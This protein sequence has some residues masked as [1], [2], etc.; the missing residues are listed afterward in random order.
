M[1]TRCM[2]SGEYNSLLEFDAL[3]GGAPSINWARTGVRSFYDNYSG[4][5]YRANFNPALT[6][7]YVGFAWIITT[8][9]ASEGAFLQWK[10]GAT[11]LGTLYYDKTIGGLRLY[12][13][14]NATLLAASAP[15]ITLSTAFYLEVHVKIHDSLGVV[16]LR[17]NG[18][19]V[20]S[21]TGD[22]QPGAE[23]SVDV[24]EWSLIDYTRTYVDDVVVNDTTGTK[25]NSWPDGMKVGVL[26]PSEA[27]STTQWTPSA[28]AN[29][30]CVDE[31]NP[32]VTDY[33]QAT[34]YDKVDLYAL[35]DLPAEAKKIHAVQV[36][37]F[38]LRA[39]STVPTIKVG[40]K[41]DGTEYYSD[42]KALGLTLAKQYNV[43]DL[44]PKTGLEW[45]L[46]DINALEVGI[47]SAA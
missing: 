3:S 36:D 29:Y 2:I 46:A 12:R 22:T 1:A 41:T 28:G 27:G 38:A 25:N 44:N 7:F 30:E 23:T 11:V 6:E 26:R 14:A 24:V 20:L 21:F 39:G 31:L 8:V 34:A 42:G 35:P 43:W 16:E 33:V 19:P 37:A 32:S 9:N 10:S 5:Y 18:L 15:I 4:G 47:K 17:V 40:L 13:G 45:S